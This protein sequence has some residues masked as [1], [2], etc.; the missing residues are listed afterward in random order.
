MSTTSSHSALERALHRLA[1]ATRRAQ[2]GLADLEA[3]LFRKELRATTMGAPVFITA[4]PRAG[5]T[6]LLE[7]L[8]GCP[9]FATQTYRDMPFVLCPMLWRKF[10]RRARRQSVAQERAHG[11]GIVISPDSPEAFEEVLWLTFFGKHY[12]THTITPWRDCR[13]AEFLEFFAAHRRKVVA[14][15]AREEPRANRYLAK[16][17]QNIARIGA[18]LDA[19]PEAMVVVPFR[20]PLQQATSLLQQHLHFSA[21]H[22]RD[23]FAKR[24]MADLGHFDFGANL[25]PIDFDDWHGSRAPQAPQHLH[26]WLDYWLATYRHLLT[27]PESP[28]LTFV[29][30]ERLATTRQVTALAHRLGIA[31]TAMLAKSAERLRPLPLRPVDTAGLPLSLL[32][33]LQETLAALQQRALR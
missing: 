8:A 27:H 23:A 21:L 25:R 7:V 6:M 12:G 17:N 9:E 14:L 22:Q 29:D 24:Y 31:D 26:F 32:S 1:F 19:V 33:A 3:R 5:T 11:D 16:N 4:L 30:F 2:L 28:R 18:L 15:R 20:D 13:N 10:S